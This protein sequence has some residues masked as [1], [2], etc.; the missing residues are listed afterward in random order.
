MTFETAI[1]NPERYRD[2]LSVLKEFEGTVLNDSNLLDILYYLYQTGI[3]SSQS[4]NFDTATEYA[5]KQY[6]KKINSTRNSDGGFPKGYQSRFWTYVRTLCELGFVYASYNENLLISNIAKS[7]IEGDID[8]QTAF[9]TQSVIYNRRSPYRNVL[10]D[11][12]YFRFIIEVL[13]ELWKLGRELSYEQFIVSLFSKTGSVT[14]FIEVLNSNHFGDSN[15]AY[16]YLKNNYSFITKINTVTKDY[17]DVVLRL[18]R[19]T[20]FVSI[21]YTGKTYI[22][23]NSDNTNYIEKIFAHCYTF[24]K[25]EKE[26]GKQFFLKFNIYSNLI[27][28][29]K[30]IKYIEDPNDYKNKLEQIIKEHNIDKERIDDLI[31]NLVKESSIKGFKDE[32]KY[33]PEPIRLEFFLTILLHIFYGDNFTISPNYKSDSLGYPISQAPG[34]KGDIEIFSDSIYWLVEV[35][36]LRNK[37]QQLN[38]ET[39]N[40]IRHMQQNDKTSYLSLVAPII[41]EDTKNYFDTQIIM[42]LMNRKSIVNIKTF[43]ILEFKMAIQN[44]DALKIIST[45]TKEIIEKAKSTIN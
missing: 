21:R 35:T 36:L 26:D 20:G 45:Y 43:S 22:R 6:I 11:F 34:G 12:N 30:K 32:F 3:V 33:V 4:Y 17:P 2:I 15:E 13:K 39:S 23:L 10:N 14:D 37:N 16:N 9:S 7:L 25:E 19:I 24:T 40:V 1:R 27:I 29:D 41:H 31:D 8:E 28:S 18:L 5:S 44:K 42:F 38:N